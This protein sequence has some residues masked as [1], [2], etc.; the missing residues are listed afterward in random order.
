M[1]QTAKILAHPGFGP[2]F[3]VIEISVPD[4]VAVVEPD[5]AITA[6][7]RRTCAARAIP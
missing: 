2:H 7:F 1:K 4:Q 3:A 6:T 5:S